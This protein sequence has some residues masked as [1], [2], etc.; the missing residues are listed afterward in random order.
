MTNDQRM[1]KFQIQRLKCGNPKSETRNPK[2]VRNPKSEANRV[3]HRQARERKPR[4]RYGR[5]DTGTERTS[6][7]PIRISHFGFP[8]DFELRA[9][10]FG[11]WN[12][13]LEYS[14]VLG[15]W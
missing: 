14:L 15:H 13:V 2:E 7:A 6:T 3:G 12:L 4:Y 8:S 10:D 9:S 5:R 1:P 11:C